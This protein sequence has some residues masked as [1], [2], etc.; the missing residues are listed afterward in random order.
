MSMTG[1]RRAVFYPCVCSIILVV[2]CCTESLLWRWSD[3]YPS[4]LSQTRYVDNL[5]YLTPQAIKMIC[6]QPLTQPE[7][8]PKRNG[9]Y[10]RCGLPG[11]EGTYK[12]ETDAQ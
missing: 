2:A 10:L 11:I 7:L 5:K 3:S 6:N 1:V 8:L 9:L 12:I 4:L